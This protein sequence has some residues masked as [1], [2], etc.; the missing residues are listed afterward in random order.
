PFNKPPVTG[1]ELTYIAQAISSPKLSGDGPFAKQCEQW[2]EEHTH[3]KKAL[4]TPSCT[5][6][7]ELAA[8]LIDIQPGDEVIMPSFTFVSTANAFVL[9][10]AKIVFVDIRPDTMNIDETK[11]EAA[12]TTNTKAIVPV[13]YAGVSCEMDTIMAVANKYK[14]FVIEDAAQG[15]MSTYKGQSLGAIGHMATLSFHETKNYTSGGEGGALLINDQRFIQRAEILREKG[16]NRSLFFK[17]MVDKYTWVDVGSS[18][19]PSEIQAAYLYAQI[20]QAKEIN[21]T[22]LNIWNSYL[23]AF[24]KYQADGLIKL[25][26]VPRGC[27]HNAHMFYI[28]LS[29]VDVRDQFINHMKNQSILAVFHYLPLHSTLAG[30]QFSYFYGEDEYTTQESEKL[31]RLPLFFNLK[32]EEIYRVIRVAC[33]F[34]DKLV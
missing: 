14:L 2:L 28:K 29:N 21:H 27:Q 16:T 3:S 15:M 26:S 12:I 22:R 13:H 34:F 23:N 32:E 8:L 1:N 33:D 7:L 24:S 5:H 17:G 4:L 30:K 31:V 6:A 20:E 25:P 19:L 9:R 10:G 11:I 18:M